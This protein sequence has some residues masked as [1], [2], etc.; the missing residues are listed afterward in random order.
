MIF[1]ILGL[2]EAHTPNLVSPATE[3]GL[4][5]LGNLG[6]SPTLNVTNAVSAATSLGEYTMP[7]R[8]YWQGMKCLFTHLLN[9]CIRNNT[10]F[11]YCKFFEIEVYYSNSIAIINEFCKNAYYNSF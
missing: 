6:T 11:Y 4:S 9:V 3:V 10:V 5:P 8:N 1:F 2:N 7:E